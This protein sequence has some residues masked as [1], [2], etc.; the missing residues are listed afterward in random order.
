MKQREKNFKRPLNIS[1]CQIRKLKDKK[2]FNMGTI[3]CLELG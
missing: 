3:L 2:I 1:G